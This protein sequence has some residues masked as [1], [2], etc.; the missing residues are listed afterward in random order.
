MTAG[1]V[2]AR[3]NL[4]AARLL[5]EHG[6]AA[7]AVTVAADAALRVA[8]D[9]LRLLGRGAGPEP[10]TVT[11]FVRYPVA[12]RGVDPKMGRLLRSLLNRCRQVGHEAGPIPAAQA[13]AALHDATAVVDVVQDWIEQSL[14][15]AAERGARSGG[16]R[17]ARPPRRR[18]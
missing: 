11:L 12:E 14:R 13:E 16:G 18:R 9:A 17:P 6:F 4:A 2:Q 5:A 7:Q 10:G 15:V 1:I 8:D 3:E